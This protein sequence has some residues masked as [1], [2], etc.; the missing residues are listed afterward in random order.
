MS[1]KEQLAQ[2][3]ESLSEGEIQQVADY[4]AFLK[5]R[6]RMHATLSFDEV[7]AASL[8]AEFAEE[9]RCLAEEGIAQYGD[10]LLA[11]DAR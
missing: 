8:Y 5:F 3:L 1:V 2:E 4:L 11:E 10:G 9:D 7:Q 6:A